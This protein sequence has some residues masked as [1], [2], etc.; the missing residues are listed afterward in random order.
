MMDTHD[1]M[2]LHDGYTIYTDS[3]PIIS[4]Q[5]FTVIVVKRNV[6]EIVIGSQLQY[7]TCTH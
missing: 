4:T 3:V 7:K 5:Y 6:K 2:M 1:A